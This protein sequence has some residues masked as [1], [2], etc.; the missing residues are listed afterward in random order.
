MTR[1]ED[2][3]VALDRAAKAWA[4]AEYQAGTS[5]AGTDQ[6]VSRLKDMDTAHVAYMDARDALA[7]ELSS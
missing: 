4:D 1:A 2:L 3:L 7:R 5:R 6:A